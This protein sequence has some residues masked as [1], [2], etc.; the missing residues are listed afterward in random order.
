MHRTQSDY[1]DMFT[2]KVFIFQFVNFYSS[3]VYIAF[4]KGSHR[5]VVVSWSCFDSGCL[6]ELAQELLIIM[7]GKQIINNVQELVMKLKAWWQRRSFRKGQ[8]E[9]KKQEVPPWEQDYQLLVC[10][11]LFDEYLEMVLQFGFITVFVA[12]CP[13]APFFALVNN[14]VEIRLDAHKFVSE[15]RRP[16]AEQAQDIGIWFQILQLITHIAVVANA[17]LIA[18]TSSF[19][20]RAYYRFTRDSSLHGFTNFTLANSPTVFT[21][22]QNSTCKY[23]DIRDDHGK[24]RPEYFELLAVRLGFV[25]VFE[26]VVFTVSRFIDALIPDVPEE[27]QIKVKRERYMAKEALAENQ[28]VNGKNEWKCTFETGA[29]GLCTVL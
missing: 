15:Y 10:E 26:H 4:F 18:F 5:L 2:L 19:L 23:P 11:G 28:K 17:F 22:I 24:Y 20:P 9:E 6:I 14:W 3:P 8:D 12:A 25:I 1:E 29:G 27:V 7:V 16:V 21:A 13:L